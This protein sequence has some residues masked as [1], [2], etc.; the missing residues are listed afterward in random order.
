MRRGQSDY[1]HKPF[2][3]PDVSTKYRNGTW[4]NF[5]Y[6]NPLCKFTRLTLHMVMS[7]LRE[8]HEVIMSSARGEHRSFSQAKP[9]F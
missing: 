7:E 4:S 5:T 3:W 2:L 6:G 9:N 1:P 8:A